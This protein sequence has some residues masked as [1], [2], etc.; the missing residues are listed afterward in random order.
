MKREDI[1]RVHKAFESFDKNLRF[2][3]DSFD[4]DTPHF[5]DILISP[6]GHEIYRKPTFSGMYTNIKSFIPWKYRISWVRS[7]LTRTQ[8]T[9]N[10][11]V[12]LAFH[13]KKALRP[14]VDFSIFS[15]RLDQFV[16]FFKK[17]VNLSDI[18]HKE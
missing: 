1:D 5:L 16:Y 17:A 8:T 11:D 12:Q 10:P 7:L 3:Y 2:R 4:N 13:G 14:I 9:R 15:E 6:S 18:S